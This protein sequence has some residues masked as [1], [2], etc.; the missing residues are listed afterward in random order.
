MAWT[1]A[2]ALEVVLRPLLYGMRPSGCWL[3]F[4]DHVSLCCWQC[5]QTA[6]FSPQTPPSHGQ[7]HFR[8][9]FLI[10]QE[11]VKGPLGRSYPQ[12]HSGLPRPAS[13]SA[14]A[15]GSRPE[16]SK[17]THVPPRSPPEE[18]VPG[19]AWPSHAAMWWPGRQGVLSY[20]GVP[21]FVTSLGPA[22][23]PHTALLGS[24]SLASTLW[25]QAGG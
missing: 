6:L 21:G 17:A 11:P 14:C 8:F 5:M 16:H 24:T 19:S 22:S 18:N 25:F 2:T 4:E 15:P 10:P 9:T 12:S 1:L 23:H 7:T 3:A 13:A 20:G